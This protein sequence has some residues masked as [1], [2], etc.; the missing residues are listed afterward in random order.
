MTRLGKL[1]HLLDRTLN[2]LRSIEI[3]GMFGPGNLGDEAMLVAAH[4][5]LPRYRCSSYRTYFERP[6]LKAV[7]RQRP[8]SDLLVGGGTLIHGGN[9][10]WLD[11]VEMMSQRRSKVSFLGTGMAFLPEQIEDP[12]PAFERWARIFERSD[13]IH[14]RGPHSAALAQRMCGRGEVFG[15]FA[16]LLHTPEMI[17]SNHASR[18]NVVGINVG[19]CLGDQA[20]FER[21]IVRLIRHVTARAFIVFHA[22]VESDVPVINRVIAQS[23]APSSAYR[24]ETHYFDPIA[25]M[26]RV[27]NYR[28]FLGLKMHAAG[29]ALICGVPSLVI[30]YLP[31]VR[32]FLEPLGN[33]DD[34]ILE[35]P[36]SLDHTIARVETL[37]SR[38]ERFIRLGEIEATAVRQR[39][40]IR[41]IFY[42]N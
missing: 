30:A 6:V 39:A 19:E 24:V 23:G 5:H 32:D 27:R 15:D 36:L 4:K 21:Q 22:V 31:K 13:E 7:L 35:L 11:Y 34:L 41:R 18:E 28:A 17:N 38:P 12:S 14:L 40:T 2:P 10:G 3:F 33:A 26:A 25:F 9:A 42:T 37:L 29:L 8:L 1:A 16:F 20:E